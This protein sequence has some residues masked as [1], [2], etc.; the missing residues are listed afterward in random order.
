MGD[1]EV[2]VVPRPDRHSAPARN[3]A[4]VAAGAPSRLAVPLTIRDLCVGD[5][6]ACG[7]AG[8]RLHLENIAQTL[9]GVGRNDVCY[10]A[11]C[12]PSGLVLVVGGIDYARKPGSGTLCE[13]VV[14]PAMRS[15]GIGTIWI[16]AAEQRILAH[17]LRRAELGVA[18][19]N[20]RALALYDRLGYLVDGGGTDA[21]DEETPGGV[22]V[23][24]EI[25][26]LMM[27]RDLA[28]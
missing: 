25:D 23:R 11:A 2:V 7:W 5:L 22:I 19:A 17:G 12:T 1:E 26:C 3:H 8:S 15:C 24:R 28:V 13:L 14:H 6:P 18:V 4:D 20:E 21:W 27:Y 9:E 16:R 10:R